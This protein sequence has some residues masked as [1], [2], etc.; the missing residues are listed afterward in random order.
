MNSGP[1]DDANRGGGTARRRGYIALWGYRRDAV[2][3]RYHQ[4]RYGRASGLL[5]RAFV[6]GAVR[7]ALRRVPVAPGIILDFACGSGVAT[8]ALIGQRCAVV[9]VDVSMPM[10][11]LAR[12]IGPPAGGASW[13]CGDIERPPFRPATVAA[14]LCLRF[15]AHMPV[16]RWSTVLQRLAELTTGP[17]I[18]GLPMRSSSKHQWRALKRRLGFAAKR[19]PIFHLAELRPI[20]ADAGLELTARLWQSPFTDTALVIVRRTSTGVRLA[21]RCAGGPSTS[22][23][24]RLS[25]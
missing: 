5:R 6:T 17:I 7:R 24:R 25:T 22:P 19:R 21:Q 18:I 9:G 3:R 15:F 8:R 11:E 23:P 2:A 10:L 12:T 13:V 4:R 16:E 1:P 20:L 14:V